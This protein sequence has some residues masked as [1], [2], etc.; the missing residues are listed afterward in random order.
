MNWNE[1]EVS[2]GWLLNTVY[3]R[4]LKLF[5]HIKRHDS[6]DKAVLE[7]KVPGKRSQGRQRRRWKD[8]INESGIHLE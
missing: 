5:G 1:L 7:G 2:E 3:R 8:R 6:L 4:K